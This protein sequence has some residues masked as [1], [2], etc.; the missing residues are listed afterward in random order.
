MA[1]P[2]RILPINWGMAGGGTPGV[3]VE[4]P[5]S[6]IQS[7]TLGVRFGTEHMAIGYIDEFSY[8]LTRESQTVYQIEPYPNNTFGTGWGALQES[9]FGQTQYWPG[10]PCEIIP[11]KQKEIS[12]TLNRYALYS[13]NLLAAM[14]R[15]DLAG[16]EGDS[17]RDP[18]SNDPT[19]VNTYVALLQQVRPIDVFE[20]YI[21]PTTG[22]IIFGRVFM[23]C[24]ITSIGEKIPTAAQNQAVLENGTIV[25]TRI[26]PIKYYV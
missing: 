15:A 23:E 14:I 10:E 2:N 5:R 17:S 26:R 18:N 12:I 21:S 22:N 11:G 24:W 6:A 19:L 8:N 7:V 9:T 3:E 25:A 1:L 4:V 16:T 13:S 20:I